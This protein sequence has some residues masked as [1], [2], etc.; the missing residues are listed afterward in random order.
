MKKQSPGTWWWIVQLLRA[1]L[2]QRL[3][4]PGTGTSHIPCVPPVLQPVWFC[5]RAPTWGHRAS[6]RP[7]PPEEPPT[8]LGA[9]TDDLCC[10]RA[11][12]CM[13]QWL[14]PGFGRTSSVSKGPLILN[15]PSREMM[16]LQQPPASDAAARGARAGVLLLQD[17]L[18]QP[19]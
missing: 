3:P 15:K 7:E 12:R 6:L 14:F 19:F 13:L 8:P 2:G 17:Q 4:Q 11:A 16:A 5:C 1:A 10:P 9:G 18:H